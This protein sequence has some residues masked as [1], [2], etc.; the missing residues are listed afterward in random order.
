MP[1]RFVVEYITQILCWA[2]ICMLEDTGDGFDGT[3]HWQNNFLIWD[4][5][6][7]N[8]A[9][10]LT[11]GFVG[12]GQK[13][14]DLLSLPLDTDQ[15]SEEYREAYNFVW[16]LLTKSSMQKITHAKNLTISP[17]LGVLWDENPG[18]DCRPGTFGELLRYGTV[19]FEQTRK[20]IEYVKAPKPPTTM[21]KGVLEA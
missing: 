20:E 13:M 16:R 7:E 17:H 11:L 10:E 6:P 5:L 3:E 14:Y 4:V 18:K 21:K 8:W 12:C 19:H 1:A 15:N 9:G 2:R